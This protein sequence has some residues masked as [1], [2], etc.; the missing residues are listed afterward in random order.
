M[1]GD[2]TGLTVVV[3]GIGPIVAGKIV[4]RGRK[5]SLASSERQTDWFRSE[6]C[7]FLYA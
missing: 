5:K 2:R 3:V 1:P 4:R 7:Y 6:L